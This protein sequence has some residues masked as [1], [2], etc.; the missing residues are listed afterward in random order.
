MWK[1][2]TFE[3]SAKNGFWRHL[4]QWRKNFGF[5]SA[6]FTQFW[7]YKY[8]FVYYS[9]AQRTFKDHKFK[10]SVLTRSHTMK[11]HK[12][13]LPLLTRAP[14]G[15]FYNAPQWG[16]GYFEAPPSDLRNL[17]T[18]SKNS[19]GIWKP[20]KN[21]RGKSIL[22]TSGQGWNFGRFLVF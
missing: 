2:L 3:I 16:G 15:Y 22:L 7:C 1:I 18:D 20:W 8:G 4:R 10:S 6:L 12:V 13:V 14:L 17:W 5:G 19:S 9:N 11:H 21:C